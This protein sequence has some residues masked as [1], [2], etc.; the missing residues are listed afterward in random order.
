[1]AMELHEIL[2]VIQ[3]FEPIGVGARD[4]QECLL[5]Q[6]EAK[7]QEVPEVAL[8]RKILKYYFDEFTKKHY[9]KI[10]TRLNISENELKSAL[11]EIL[12][13][14]PKPGSSFSDPQNK[15]VQHIIPDFILDNQEGELQLSLNARNV[16]EHGSPLCR[17]G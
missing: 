8:G 11:D 3:D 17:I 13:L 6:I 14:N 5:L 4:L 2:K 7:D 10:I 16:P 12:K 9:D 15:N 1:M